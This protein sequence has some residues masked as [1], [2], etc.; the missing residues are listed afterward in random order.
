L[1]DESLKQQKGVAV[2]TDSEKRSFPREDMWLVFLAMGFLGALTIARE[3]IKVVYQGRISGKQAV[4]V[5][6]LMA[7]CASI[8]LFTYYRA[9]R[10]WMDKL[11]TFSRLFW[12]GYAACMALPF[13]FNRLALFQPLE[14]VLLL[15]SGVTIGVLGH[16]FYSRLKSLQES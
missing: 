4:A 5:G 8:G 1:T 6:Y 2:T 3:D 14:G 7:S 9:L 10:E 12:C 11:P 13:V 16:L 15:V